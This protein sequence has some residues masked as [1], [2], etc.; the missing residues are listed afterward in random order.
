MDTWNREELYAEIWDQPA[1]KVAAKYGISSVMLGKVCRQLQI[2]QPG[3]GYW[4]KKQFG[5]PVKKIPLPEAKDLPIVQRLKQATSETN[6]QPPNSTPEPTDP[7]YQRILKIE[8]R[9]VAVDPAATRHRLV[10]ASAKCLTH[11]EADNRGLVHAYRSETCLDVRVS[12]NSIDRA[13]NIMNAVIALLEAEKFPVF[14]KADDHG[15]TAQVFGQNIPFSIV[16]KLRQT[17]KE[18][19]RYSYTHMETLYQPN[20]ELEFR[21]GED[22]YGYRK[23]RDGKTKKLEVLISRLVGSVLREARDRAIRAE[24]RRLEEIEERKRAQERFVLREQIEAEEKKVQEFE[25]WVTNWVR[26]QQ[27]REFIVALENL[28]KE[29]GHDLSANS[30]KGERISWMKRQADRLDPLVESPPSILD[31]KNELN[32]WY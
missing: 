8:A 25:S 30:T 16:E 23:V 2:P 17:R 21:A 6:P 24:E 32:R 18:V 29:K 26:A 3:R 9:A 1:T 22:T 11:H 19:T 7:E 27:T 4:A 10:S 5:R 13:L 12:K 20:G 15:T 28:W 31:R 14:V